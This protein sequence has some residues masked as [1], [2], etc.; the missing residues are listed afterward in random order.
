MNEAIKKTGL[1]GISLKVCIPKGTKA[2]F[3]SMETTDSEAD[4]G[5]EKSAA[6]KASDAET[7]TEVNAAAATEAT[8][9]K[10]KANDNSAS[11]IVVSSVM[12]IAAIAAV[13]AFLL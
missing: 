8:P 5:V 2:S 12:S 4:S 11:S 3:K 6:T 9:E 10:I 7:D 1:K 13:A